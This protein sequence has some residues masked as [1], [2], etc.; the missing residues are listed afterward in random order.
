MRS[1]LHRKTIHSKSRVEEKFQNIVDL[2][3]DLDKKE[4]NRLQEGM[5]LAW[6]AYNKVSQAKTTTEKEL[7]DIEGPERILEEESGRE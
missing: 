1:L 5:D 7:E 4:F 6:R 3:K 2:I